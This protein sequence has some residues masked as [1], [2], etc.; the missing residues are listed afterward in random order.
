[1]IAPI[2]TSSRLVVAATSCIEIAPSLN[3]AATRFTSEGGGGGDCMP[4]VTACVHTTAPIPARSAP[5][6]MVIPGG[7]VGFALDI[8]TPTNVNHLLA[9]LSIVRVAMHHHSTQ[10]NAVIC[11]ASK[12][13]APVIMDASICL[14][15]RAVVYIPPYRSCHNIVHVSLSAPREIAGFSG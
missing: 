7:G 13:A 8:R 2:V 6:K 15:V 12:T 5:A 3:A 9:G 4:L 10:S 1:M 14:C 11:V